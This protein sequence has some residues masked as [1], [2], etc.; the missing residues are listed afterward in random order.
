MPE[1]TISEE[2]MTRSYAFDSFATA[3]Q[4][5]TSMA[6]VSEDLNH[7]PTWTNTYNR[8]TVQLTTHDIGGLSDLDLRWAGHADQIAAGLTDSAKDQ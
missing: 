4:F 8:V 5:M 6:E 7:H 3:M 2:E 1:W